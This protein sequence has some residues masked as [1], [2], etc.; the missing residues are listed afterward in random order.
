MEWTNLVIV[1]LVMSLLL[2]AGRCKKKMKN[3]RAKESHSL[4]RGLGQK[5]GKSALGAKRIPAGS[6]LLRCRRRRQQ[7]DSSNV[8]PLTLPLVVVVVMII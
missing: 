6:N 7:V 1:G 8:V 4:N 5:W 3:K 2:E